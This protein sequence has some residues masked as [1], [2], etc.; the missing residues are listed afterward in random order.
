MTFLFQ[1]NGGLPIHHLAGI[2]VN[3]EA[4]V[5]IALEYVRRDAIREHGNSVG[6]PRG[7]LDR[8]LNIRKEDVGWLRPRGSR[9]SEAGM[10]SLPHGRF[11]CTFENIR[12]R[13]GRGLPRHGK[14]HGQES[15][16]RRNH[17]LGSL[18]D[19]QM[20]LLD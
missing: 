6:E 10:K 1:L 9:S 20:M 19:R 15:G 13:V 11:D 3:V 17:D 7:G 4:V 12:G 18:E 14:V 2:H 5:W 8:Y 16:I